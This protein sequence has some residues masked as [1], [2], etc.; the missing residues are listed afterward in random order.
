LRTG[1]KERFSHVYLSLSSSVLNVLRPVSIGHAAGET[2][3]RLSTLGASKSNP[4]FVMKRRSH[5]LTGLRTG[6][7]R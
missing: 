5:H 4:A 6:Q 2:G 7:L 1:A 3:V